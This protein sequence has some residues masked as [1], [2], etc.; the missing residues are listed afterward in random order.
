[1][2]ML[3]I[4]LPARP[5]GGSPAQEAAIA[6]SHVLSADGLA[7]GTQGRASAAQ[8]PRA[9]TVVAVLPATEIAWHR[10]D[11][12]RAPAGR[13]RAALAG[14]L[15]ERLLDEDDS[16]HLA[17]APQARA[18]QPTWVA[19]LSKPWLA[20]HLAALEQAGVAVE[21]VVPAQAPGAAEAPHGHFFAVPRQGAEHDA[22]PHEPWLALADGQGVTTLS[23]DGALARRLLGAWKEQPVQWTA[24]PAVAAA[25]ER[26]L[27]TPVQVRGEADALLAAARS[28]WN[29]RQFDL[30]ARNRGLRTLRSLGKRLMSP[31]W[32]PVRWGLAAL[33]LLQVAGLNLWAWQQQRAISQREL[34]MNEMLRASHPQV[35]AVLDAPA[36]MQRETELLRAAAGRAGDTDLEPLLMLAAQAWPAD[37]APVQ[38]L[39]YEP[40]KLTLVAP[41][42]NAQQIEQ[43]RSRAGAA[44]LALD[45]SEGR[46]TLSRAAAPR[47]APTTA[48]GA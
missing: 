39:R 34:A 14:L 23:L 6:Y 18:G 16:V 17:V 7:A 38:S 3:V 28:D 24:E 33:L 8:L 10:V 9:D 29:L 21:R 43:F 22:D 37:Q 26:W 11:L 20:T 1:M 36:Q 48:K 44:G 4:Q 15:E 31:A 2:S 19:A 12:P 5:R 46:L 42:L 32:R 30:G 35:R 45:S 41:G 40:G 47:P 13:L 25:A 27:G